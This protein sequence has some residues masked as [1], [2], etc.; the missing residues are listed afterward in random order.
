MGRI[1]HLDTINKLM[2]KEKVNEVSLKR[3]IK[4]KILS[5]VSP[6][7][8]WKGDLVLRKVGEIHMD[9]K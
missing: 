5:R 9:S 7:E 1:F 2:D 3:R 8:F 4:A 6:K